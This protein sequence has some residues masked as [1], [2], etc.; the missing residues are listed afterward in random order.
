MSFFY[1]FFDLNQSYYQTHRANLLTYI[2]A[3]HS[4]GYLLLLVLAKLSIPILFISSQLQCF[5]LLH[6]KHFETDEK[7]FC[8][9]DESVQH[10]ITQSINHYDELT[11]VNESI[12]LFLVFFHKKIKLI[13]MSFVHYSEIQH[14]CFW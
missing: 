1:S 3:R 11:R 13:S 9:I 10:L 4:W 5:F 14:R 2:I 12:F 6:D 8:R 7:C